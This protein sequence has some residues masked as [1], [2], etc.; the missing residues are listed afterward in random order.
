MR[1]SD[2]ADG[3]SPNS[4]ADWISRALP[5]EILSASPRHERFDGVAVASSSSSSTASSGIIAA[6]VFERGWPRMGGDTQHA[7][8]AR[9]GTV[10][11]KLTF[12]FR[13]ERAAE[14]WRKLPAST[15]VNASETINRRARENQRS[16]QRLQAGKRPAD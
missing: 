5:L 9:P 2:F 12:R 13:R 7:I 1:G 10:A 4:I 8:K 14:N 15:S 16:E 6:A 11:L 3:V